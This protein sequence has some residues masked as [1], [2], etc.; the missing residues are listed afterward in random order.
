MKVRTTARKAGLLTMLSM[1]LLA[2]GCTDRQLL[3]Q[4]SAYAVVDEI[5]AASG[6]QP[7]RFSGALESDVVTYRRMTLD[8]NVAF[9]RTIFEDFARVTMHLA[10]KDPGT[11]DARTAPSPVNAITFT[12]YHV[13]YLRTDGRNVPGVDVPYSFD[14]G[15]TLTVAGSTAST[16]ELVLVRA[17][18]KDE[19]PLRALAA[20]RDDSGQVV[21]APG[22]A[23]AISTIA[24]LSFDGTD[25]AGRAVTATAR[26]SVNFADW[27]DPDSNF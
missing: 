10:L 26:I 22:G 17:Q 7:E 25:Q 21:K 16:A 3:G 15:M 14:G 24:E 5:A 20:A 11:A 2:S 12:R 9:V 18:A 1:D 6:A 13:A 23:I 19:A 4:S 8:G 27:A